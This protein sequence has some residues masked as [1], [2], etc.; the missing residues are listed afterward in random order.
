MLA[1]E[2]RFLAGRYHATPWGRHVNEG[3]VDW[4]PEPWRLLRALISTW[5]HKVRTA[6]RH[7]E[8]TLGDLIDSLAKT[9]PEFHLPTASQSHTRHYMPQRRTGERPKLVFDAFAAVDRDTPLYIGWPNLD[10]PDKQTQLLDELLEAMGYLGRTESWVEARRLSPEEN[11]P[12]SNCKPGND[13]INYV[14]GELIGE[15]VNVHS[16]I[17]ASEYVV[18]RERYFAD[19]H[20]Q[21]DLAK[22]LP[23][24][25]LASLSLQTAELQE[26]CWS[27]PPAAEHVT[28]VR[29]LDALRPQRKAP[30]QSQSLET[31][32]LNTTARF[33]LLGKPLPRAEEC[34]RIGELMRMTVLS[35]FEKDAAGNRLAPSHISGHGLREDNRHGHAFYLPFDSNGDGRLD[36]IVLHVPKGLGTARQVIGELSRSKRRL[37]T[38]NG[39]EWR[40]LLEGIGNHEVGGSLTE[41]GRHWV[42]VTPY[43]HPWHSKKSLNVADQIRRECTL[44]KLPEVIALNS[45]PTI[46]VG[47]RDRRPISFLRYRTLKRGQH[48]PDRMGSF[49]ELTF[50]ETVQGPLALGFACH[51]GLGLFIAKAK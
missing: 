11:M 49:W 40:I 26:K 47:S 1:L 34:L 12:V 41:G 38:R 19:K 51:F 48:Q 17:S 3:E 46:R 7:D 36:R 20:Q 2:I 31:N 18:R 10:L 21:Q 39:S 33:L 14:T 37:R 35:A 45:I 8:S 23:E 16:P 27:A 30:S 6:G 43:L 29:P 50:A 13:P 15:V 5:H 9:P 4:P 24:G 44:R 32:L 22:S 28:Y 25:L 42:S